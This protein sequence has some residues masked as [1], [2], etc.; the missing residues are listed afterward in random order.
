MLFNGATDRILCRAFPSTL[1]KVA[2][3]WYSSFK[4]NFIH[5]FNQLGRSFV[6]HF[7]SNRWL[8]RDS[9]FLINIKQG[10]RESLRSYMSQFKEA[11]LEIWTMQSLWLEM[12]YAKMSFSS[13]KKRAPV[14]FF[15]MMA[16]AKKYACAE[17]VYEAHGPPSSPVTKERPLT[18]ESQPRR[19]D[20]GK[21]R[22]RSRSPLRCWRIPCWIQ[23][24][25]SPP[26]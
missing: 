11:T 5:S 26:N 25:Q 4:P 6:A 13:W 20:R 3:Y 24:H 16:R 18:Q 14:N 17:E 12:W 15:K 10:K 23:H 8:C 7:I 1:R 22:Q 19:E 2:R 21:E 9:D